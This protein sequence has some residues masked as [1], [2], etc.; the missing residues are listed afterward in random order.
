MTSRKADV[1][2]LVI[3]YEH[4]QHQHHYDHE[5]EPGWG[6]WSRSII[7]EENEETDAEVSPYRVQ[8]KAQ[9]YPTKP[10]LTLS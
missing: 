5:E 2:I 3:Y 6:P 9:M 1:M 10:L 8:E 7:P 4:A